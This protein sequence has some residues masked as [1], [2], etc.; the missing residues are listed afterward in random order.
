MIKWCLGMMVSVCMYAC[1]VVK[2]VNIPVDEI[3]ADWQIVQN[4]LSAH[5]VNGLILSLKDKFNTYVF[6]GCD[7]LK[8]TPRYGLQQKVQVQTVYNTTQKCKD[9]LVN[10]QVKNLLKE[11]DAYHISNHELV[12]KNK[13]GQEI[14]KA[15]KT[16]PKLMRKWMVKNMGNIAYQKLLELGAYI[17]FTQQVGNASVFMGCNGIG[18]SYFTKGNTIKFTGGMGTMMY[19]EGKMEA[20]QLF[21]TLLHKIVQFKIEGHF[22]YLLDKNNK[23]LIT[24]VAE[25]WD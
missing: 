4:S 11:V 3:Y 8:F 1:S 2:P 10:Q 21:N 16:E 5:E 6:T 19:C 17:D 20:E 25:D 7:T 14:M 9:A 22:L 23:E 13:Q 24:L 18:A 12:L 15:V